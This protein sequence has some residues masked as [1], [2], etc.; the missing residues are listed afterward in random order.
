MIKML[1]NF[2][3]KI[4]EVFLFIINMVIKIFFYLYYLIFKFSSK[5]NGKDKKEKYANTKEDSKEFN[6]SINFNKNNYLEKETEK[7]NNN[8]F[9]DVK[10]YLNK[11]FKRNSYNHINY[12]NAD[13]KNEEILEKITY[14]FGSNPSKI[15]SNKLNINKYNF[16]KILIFM[17]L[18]FIMLNFIL[19]LDLALIIILIIIML[20]YFIIKFPEFQRKNL[21]SSISKDLPFALRHMAC[22]LKSGKGLNN[23]LISIV[24]SDYGILSFEYN[25]VI[26]EVEYGQT[27]DSALNDMSNRIDSQGLRRA[28]QQIISAQKLGSNLSDSLFIIA[29]DIAF[30]MRIKLKNYSQKLNGYIMIYTFMVILAPVVLLI[31]TI[32]ASTVVGVIMPPIALYIIYGIFFPM[33]IIFMMLLIKKLEPKV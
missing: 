9:K 6:K 18:V 15:I 32:A 23:T 7:I 24:K 20:I 27:L 29:E 33:I 1:Y 25:R 2:F 16:K 12:K 21:Y 5:Y 14:R 11:N 19:S 30:D 8:L 17:I 31:M 28:N 4:S 3:I 13:L 10:Y 26:S 22:E